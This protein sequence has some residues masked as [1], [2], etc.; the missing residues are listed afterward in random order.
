MAVWYLVAPLWKKGKEDAR[1][2]V[3]R[4]KA[5][6][7]AKDKCIEESLEIFGQRSIV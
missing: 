1:D 5:E 4:R 6:I 7:I 3:E 2:W